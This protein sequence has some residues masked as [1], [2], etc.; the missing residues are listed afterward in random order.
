MK[1]RLSLNCMADVQCGLCLS[2]GVPFFPDL[3]EVVSFNR[4]GV[5]SLVFLNQDYKDNRDIRALYDTPRFSSRRHTAHMFHQSHH[6]TAIDYMCTRHTGDNDVGNVAVPLAA[7]AVVP[8]LPNAPFLYFHAPTSQAGRGPEAAVWTRPP[9]NSRIETTRLLNFLRI[10]AAE[11]DAVPVRR[12]I[13]YTV[14]TCE[15]CNFLMTQ[16]ANMRYILG[17]HA[18]AHRNTHGPVITPNRP[19]FFQIPALSGRHELQNA[20]GQ[21][22]LGPIP[23]VNV[24]RPARDGTDSDSSHVAYYL[25]LCLPRMAQA[26]TNVFHILIPLGAPADLARI[27]RLRTSA[28]CLFLEQ[29]WLL[30]EIAAMATLVEEGKVT[31]VNQPLSHGMQQHYGVLDLYVSYFIFRLVQFRYGNLLRATGVDFVQWHQKYYWDMTRCKG[32]F[33]HGIQST[34]FAQTAYGTTSQPSKALIEQIGRSLVR[35][36]RRN[37]LMLIRMVIGD[38]QRVPAPIKNYFVPPA[39][40]R[41]MR[42]WSRQVLVRPDFFG[43]IGLA[44]KGCFRAGGSRRPARDA[45]SLRGGGAALSHHRPVRGL[46]RRVLA[47]SHGFSRQLAAHRA[48]AG[49]RDQRRARRVCG[50]QAVLHGGHARRAAYTAE[51]QGRLLDPHLRRAV[52]VVLELRAG[53]LAH[54]GVPGARIRVMG[55]GV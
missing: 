19:G 52:C 29:C 30:L 25:H 7:N 26:A 11:P 13:G 39:A 24:A 32:L 36:T 28:R 38:H 3:T 33:P 45:E 23:A 46:P 47:E 55:S 22:R 41:I 37:L 42:G 12:D 1:T 17:H 44:D 50:V 53:A 31:D 34:V 5:Q 8:N 43:V 4:I 48:R 16:L 40:L 15:G 18:V 27:T 9:R 35:F 2:C 54:R 20:Y 10:A 51:Q 49:A 21:W 14:Y 6:A